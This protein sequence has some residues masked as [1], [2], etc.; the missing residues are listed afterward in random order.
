MV[1][2]PTPFNPSTTIQYHLDVA[3]EVSLEVYDVLGAAVAQLVDARQPAGSYRVQWDA[4]GKAAG[5]YFC[6]LRAGA[7]QVVSGLNLVR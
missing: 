1:N 5:R 3:A 2:F 6:V 7:S 4:S